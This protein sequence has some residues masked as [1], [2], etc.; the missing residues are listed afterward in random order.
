MCLVSGASWSFVRRSS[1]WFA[2]T[3]RHVFAA[4]SGRMQHLVVVISEGGGGFWTHFVRRRHEKHL[5]KSL[6]TL[7]IQKTFSFPCAEAGGNNSTPSLPGHA[8]FC[9]CSASSSI[10]TKIQINDHWQHR[11][12]DSRPRPGFFRTRGGRAGTRQRGVTRGSCLMWVISGCK[13]T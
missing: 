10:L 4:L 6:P 1:R 2:A 12:G 7:G 9:A 3:L 13:S 11:H 8:W 5:S